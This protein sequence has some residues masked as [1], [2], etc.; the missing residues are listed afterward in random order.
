MASLFAVHPVN[1]SREGEYWY[2]NPFNVVLFRP[3]TEMERFHEEG[4][5]ITDALCPFAGE[6]RAVDKPVRMHTCYEKAVREF[7]EIL[8]VNT[9]GQQSSMLCTDSF[10][11]VRE[12]VNASMLGGR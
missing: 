4:C 9:L 8:F 11:K 5:G 1:P 12:L 10:D 6:S 3:R 2:V 7:T